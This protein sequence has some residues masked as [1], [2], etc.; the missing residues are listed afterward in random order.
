M[1]LHWGR[2]E[3]HA[4]R[5]PIKTVC[6]SVHA[7]RGGVVL[8]R[9]LRGSLR[10]A[11]GSRGS[12]PVPA[13]TGDAAHC[14]RCVS[15]SPSLQNLATWHELALEISFDSPIG[16]ARELIESRRSRKMLNKLTKVSS[17]GYATAGKE[18]IAMV[19]S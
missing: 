14:V 11:C 17:R 4:V 1:E 19:G 9:R 15:R 13:R 12:R 7:A 8:L 5:V 6:L 10:P 18:K 2:R 3:D 16:S